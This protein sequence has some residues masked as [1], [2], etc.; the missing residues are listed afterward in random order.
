MTL[1]SIAELW[2]NSLD[3]PL[4]APD[5]RRLAEVLMAEP[6]LRSQ[7]LRDA[8]LHGILSALTHI[9]ETEDEFVRS[10]ERR[11]SNASTDAGAMPTAPT[12]SDAESSNAA[13]VRPRQASRREVSPPPLPPP[14][15]ERRQ[16]PPPVTRDR[17]T[18][19]RQTQWAV[20]LCAVAAMALIST[21]VTL[22]I[23]LNSDDQPVADA[24]EFRSH[25]ES[26]RSG[27]QLHPQPATTANQASPITD[28]YE[29]DGPADSASPAEVV[30]QPRSN[31]PP[32]SPMVSPLAPQP[33]IVV[34]QTPSPPAASDQ[35]DPMPAE[36][37][38]ITDATDAVWGA[39]IPQSLTDQR[40]RLREGTVT[41][42]MADGATLS[43]R[44]PAEFELDSKNSVY[45]FRGRLVAT[46][47][48]PALG[49]TVRSPSSRVVDLGTEFV[50]DVDDRGATAV[51]VLRGEVEVSAAEAGDEG[52]RWQLTS[53][54]YKWL[55][56]D[57]TQSY[58]WR[59]HLNVDE[60]TFDGL[61]E[62]NGETF[63]FGKSAEYVAL[64]PKMTDELSRLRRLLLSSLSRSKAD[65]FRAEI[66]LNDRTWE[67]TNTTEYGQ[68][69]RSINDELRRLLSEASMKRTGAQ[70]GFNGSFMIDG[71]EF[72][73]NDFEDLR[74]L[75]DEIRRRAAEALK[76]KPEK[77]SDDKTSDDKAVDERAVDERPLTRKT[78][79]RKTSLS[80]WIRVRSK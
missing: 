28:V 14:V 71:E 70:S 43:V 47:P 62:M 39:P 59:L 15:I 9:E 45:L 79:T 78:L 6:E 1:R 77:A 36:Y 4:N 60:N 3:F 58:D 40:L 22:V 13:T 37:G 69:Y 57:G 63:P 18:P 25:D 11:L 42:A 32:A 52:Q 12:S 2:A 7:A 80:Q 68:A 8:E 27:D 74:K 67:I 5:D 20:L 54:Q 48:E 35:P 66:R 17:K 34:D 10:V 19:R 61:L 33:R 46:V 50:V 21:G 76:H 29:K 31:Q 30:E 65:P 16:S 75:P 72:R 51:Q 53:G 24:P 23:E 55:S 26:P 41:V 73:I 49:F 44:G 38:R 64:Y 56:G